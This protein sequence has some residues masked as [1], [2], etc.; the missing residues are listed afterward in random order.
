MAAEN[1]EQEMLSNVEYIIRAATPSDA[2]HLSAIEHAADQLFRCANTH[3]I[4]DLPA[5]PP[6][7]YLPL[8]AAGQ[9]W[10][11]YPASTPS[12][13]IAF[14]AAKLFSNSVF[15]HQLSVHPSVGRQGIGKALMQHAEYWARRQGYHAVE[16]TTFTDVPFNK[17]YYEGLG[18]RVLVEMELQKS[19]TRQL[20]EQL[21]REQ[22]D[23]VL[24]S[25][26]RV[27]MRKL[28]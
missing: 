10:V 15:I 27:A 22:V 21:R 20:R 11:A 16:L 23:M 9:A 24:G 5:N 17:P 3:L 1:A 28:L 6:T 4:A 8:I 18:Y 12:V 14:I 19:E 26:R 2:P 13:P 7:D 25:W